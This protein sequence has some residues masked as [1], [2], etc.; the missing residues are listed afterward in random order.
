MKVFSESIFIKF[1][2]TGEIIVILGNISWGIGKIKFF[3][4]FS[5]NA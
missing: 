4:F 2:I 5:K 3:N 1:F